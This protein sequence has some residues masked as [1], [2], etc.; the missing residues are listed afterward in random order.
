MNLL[1]KLTPAESLILI[2]GK[3]ATQKELIKVTFMD[4]LLKQVIRTYDVKWQASSYD[5]PIMF[6]YTER[7]KNFD[8]YVS[9]EHENIFVRPFKENPNSRILFRHIVR[10]GF[11]NSSSQIDFQN[12]ILSN[13]ILKDCYS[14][15]LYQKV[16]GGYSLSKEGKD[17]QSKL[18][19]EIDQVE[20]ILPNYIDTNK[21]KAF[22]VLKAIKGNVFLLT[23]IKFE[24]LNHIDRELI[25]EMNR[26]D[27][28]NSGNGCYSSW[29]SFDHY[30]ETFDSTSN[31]ESGGSGC[32]GDS[33]CGGGD[34]GCSGCGG[35]GGD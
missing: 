16:F 9:K 11:E 32:W 5:A 1:S 6:K 22:E 4:L 7:G 13:G 33:G 20:N 34:S 12:I 35:C 23:N 30:S 2:D 27:D 31:S 10:I 18:L 14:K 24:L 3:K 28:D 8:K 19:K 29:D 26:R 25:K 17:I 15:N 21:E